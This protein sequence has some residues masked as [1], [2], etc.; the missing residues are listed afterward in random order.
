MSTM[1]WQG[2]EFKGGTLEPRH[3][4]REAPA[5]GDTVREDM[6]WDPEG[7]RSG[8]RIPL[9]AKRCGEVILILIFL[10]AVST[11]HHR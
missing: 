6:K 8:V 3:F 9:H 1:G 2:V 7:G 4:T 11:S 5:H 10:L